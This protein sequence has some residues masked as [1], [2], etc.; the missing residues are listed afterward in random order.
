MDTLGGVHLPWKAPWDCLLGR[1]RLP[2]QPSKY[3]VILLWALA[4]GVRLNCLTDIGAKC[5]LLK[6]GS[7]SLHRETMLWREAGCKAGPV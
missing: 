2:V 5:N 4:P 6:T 3:G 7:K 1:Q